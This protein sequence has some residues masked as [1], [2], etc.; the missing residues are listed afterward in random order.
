MLHHAAMPESG[1]QPLEELLG[2][3]ATHPA[4]RCTLMR[5]LA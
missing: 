1:L 3:L 4:S 5:N 2:L